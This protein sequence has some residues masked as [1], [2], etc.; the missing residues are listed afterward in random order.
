VTVEISLSHDAR[1]D[2]AAYL[3]QHPLPLARRVQLT[4]PPV[5]VQ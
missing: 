4:S 1:A 3:E 2:V 5:L